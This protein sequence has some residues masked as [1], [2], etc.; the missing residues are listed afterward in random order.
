MIIQFYKYYKIIVL[1]DNNMIYSLS[2]NI[3]LLIFFTCYICL[4]IFINISLINN[5][6]APKKVTHIVMDSEKNIIFSDKFGDIYKAETLMMMKQ[7]VTSV[8]LLQD[9]YEF[10]EEKQLAKYV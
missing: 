2:V 1:F 7:G 6:T 10:K 9:Y 5:S 3:S 4:L 8:N